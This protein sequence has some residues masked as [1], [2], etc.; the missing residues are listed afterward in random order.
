MQIEATK[1]AFA[2]RETFYGDP[3]FVDVPVDVLLSDAYNAERRKLIT[4]R[5]SLE[6]RPGSV[7]QEEIDTD[8]ARLLSAEEELRKAVAGEN[9]AAEK[10]RS[11]SSSLESVRQNIA[12]LEAKEREEFLD[13]RLHLKTVH[14]ELV[15]LMAREPDLADGLIRYRPNLLD[16]IRAGG[17]AVS[18]GGKFAAVGQTPT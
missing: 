5:A 14:E 7:S 15:A 6:Q 17:V 16:Y 9:V 2:D 4:D 1:L 18:I 12:Q 11:G 13:Y 8:H 10:L 3:K